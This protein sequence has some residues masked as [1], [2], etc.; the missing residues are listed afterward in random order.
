MINITKPSILFILHLPPPIHGAANIGLNIKQSSLINNSFNCD[1]INLT[2]Q[3]N[4]K[5]MGK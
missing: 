5:D 2:T 1:Y 3:A 4:L